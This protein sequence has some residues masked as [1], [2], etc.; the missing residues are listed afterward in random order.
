VI[1]LKENESIRTGL[2]FRCEKGVH[3]EVRNACLT[4]GKWLRSEFRFPIRLVIYLKKAEKIK[5]MD[6]DFVS[7]VFFA[8][9]NKELE[10]YAKVSTGDYLELV[11]DW[12]KNEALASILGSIA[13][14]I[15][16]Y[17]QWVNNEELEEELEELRANE[18]KEYVLDLYFP[19]VKSLY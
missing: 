4:F 12:G 17:Y 9:F 11:T 13:H 14:E 8:P 16:H 7:A 1:G 18:F 2:R 15:G 10:P 19:T 6:K 5:T 3:P